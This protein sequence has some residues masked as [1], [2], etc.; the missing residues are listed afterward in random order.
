MAD[1]SG[2]LLR[3]GDT[4]QGRQEGAVHGVFLQNI[5]SG[6]LMSVRPY[7]NTASLAPSP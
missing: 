2:A 3:E 5:L 4:N 6:R 7:L 1:V